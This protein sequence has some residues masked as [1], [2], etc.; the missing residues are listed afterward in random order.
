MQ[1]STKNMQV[2]STIYHH[3]QRSANDS[4]WQIGLLYTRSIK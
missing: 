1:F 2:D 4:L 3:M